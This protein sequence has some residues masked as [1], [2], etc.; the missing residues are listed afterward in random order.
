[1]GGEVAAHVVGADAD[2]HGAQAAELLGR[3]VVA[4]ETGNLVAHLFQALGHAVTGAGDV[5]DAPALDREV[6]GD[7]LQP[8]GRL[9][10]LHGDVLVPDLDSLAGPGR[11]AHVGAGRDAGRGRFGRGPDRERQ[12]RAVAGGREPERLRVRGDLP[13]ARHVEVERSRHLVTRGRD[14]DLDL[15]APSQAR[16]AARPTGTAA[17]PARSR[18]AAGPARPCQRPACT[19]VGD[20]QR[21]ATHLEL[22]LDRE[23]LAGSRGGRSACRS[24]T[25]NIPTECSSRSQ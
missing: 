9:E 13:S 1:M 14:L 8:R 7:G 17:P 4:G 20:L 12:L 3:K 21:L 10:Q 5:A 19:V 18:Q 16:R 11:V 23:R 22:V 15:S 25:L 6:E 24:S 2:H